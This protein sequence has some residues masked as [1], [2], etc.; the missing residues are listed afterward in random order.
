MSLAEECLLLQVYHHKPSK[1]MLAGDFTDVLRN[2]D[3]SYALKTMCATT[4]NITEA[5][6]TVCRWVDYLCC[7]LWQAA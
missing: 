2:E 3:G 4:C 7:V 5:K 1:Y 6:E